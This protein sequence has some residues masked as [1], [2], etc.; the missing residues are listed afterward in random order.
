LINGAFS[1]GSLLCMRYVR[2]R[3]YSLQSSNF[4]NAIKIFRPNVLCLC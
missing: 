3:L 1:D 4:S 2:R